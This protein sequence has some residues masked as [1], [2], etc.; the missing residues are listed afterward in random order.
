MKGFVRRLLGELVPCLQTWEGIAHCARGDGL[1]VGLREIARVDCFALS[2]SRW[3]LFRVES[4]GRRLLDEPVPCLRRR[5]G[6]AHCA[7]GDG[8][9]VSLREIARFA[10]V[11][12]FALSCS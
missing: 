10:R 4:F 2:C 7:R 9:A 5:E 6:I 1:A 8:L 12:C 11:D 3:E